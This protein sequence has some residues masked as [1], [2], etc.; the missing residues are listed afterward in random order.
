MSKYNKVNPGQYTQRGRL[1]PDE[2]ARELDKQR[3]AASP[4]QAEGSKFGEADFAAAQADQP[5]DERETG[6]KERAAE[7][8]TPSPR[9][10][11]PAPDRHSQTKRAQ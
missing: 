10:D 1:T 6:G 8:D 2:T 3:Q 9:E 11:P 7:T 4:K 5:I